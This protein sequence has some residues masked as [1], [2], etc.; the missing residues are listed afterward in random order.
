MERR[1]F[2]LQP[3]KF[4]MRTAFP[5]ST[6]SQRWR[7][8]PCARSLRHKRHFLPCT[9]SIHRCIPICH[10][11]LRPVC[12]PFT[13]LC[14]YRKYSHFGI[15]RSIIC[16]TKCHIT[17]FTT[18]GA[19]KTSHQ[20]LDIKL[21]LLA[22]SGLSTHHRL[23]GKCVKCK[24]FSD[25][26]PHIWH[27]QKSET[28]CSVPKLIQ[29]HLNLRVTKKDPPDSFCE[30]RSSLLHR[31]DSGCIVSALVCIQARHFT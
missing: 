18:T 29:S 14:T 1:K 22:E 17:T 4:Q 6:E 16:A 7:R 31:Q 23:R 24:Q 27:S 28:E 26:Y 3:P 30:R 2:R 5:R 8:P 21:E 25:S 9:D 15:R 12:F 11:C 10:S 13:Y 19:G 20:H